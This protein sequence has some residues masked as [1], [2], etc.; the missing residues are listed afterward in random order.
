MPRFFRSQSLPLTVVARSRASAL[1]GFGS[2]LLLGLLVVLVGFTGATTAAAQVPRILHYQ[3]TLTDGEFPAEGPVDVKA[4][5]YADSTGGTPLTGWEESWSAVSLEDGRLDLQLGDTRPIPDEVLEESTLYLQLTVD[6]EV[7]PRLRVTSTAFA[8]RAAVA[9]GVADGGLTAESFGDGIVGEEALA[10]GAVT[11]DAMADGAVT[12]DVLADQSVTRDKLTTASVTGDALG[13]EVVT[14]QKLGTG[15]VDSRVLADGSVR[16]E[17]LGNGAVTSPKIASGTVVSSLNDLTDD[18]R[19][20]EGKNIEITSSPGQ[21]TI[22][23]AVPEGGKKEGQLSSRRWKTDVRP[24]DGLRLVESLQGVRYRWKDS[25][26]ED[27]GL[28][29]EEVGAIL[30][31]VVTYASNGRDAETVNYAKLVSVLI[32]A[33]KTQQAEIE[34]TRERLRSLE[35]RLDALEGATQEP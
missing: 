30:P 29:A 20:V 19:L 35:R 17:T 34:E 5:F 24:L 14:S 10:D 21:G 9:E 11:T 28:I 2:P 7:L 16:T 22:T 13:D 32:E 23:I 1:L 6:G 25:G 4:S 8:L 26:R 33:V 12:S 27:V 15:A 31:E 3:A 18:V